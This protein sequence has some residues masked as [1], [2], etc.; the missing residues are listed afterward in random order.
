MKKI[1]C[2]AQWVSVKQ[3][4]SNGGAKDFIFETINNEQDSKVPPP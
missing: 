1:L 3:R 4:S 2:L